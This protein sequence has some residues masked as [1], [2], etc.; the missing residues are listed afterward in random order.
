M[1]LVA[2]QFESRRLRETRRG[3]LTILAA[4]MCIVL[5]GMVAFA[6]DIG[7][8]LSSK[9]EIQRTADAWALAAAWEF[10]DCINEGYSPEDAMSIAR[11]VDNS[12][13][14]SNHVGN[15][16]PSVRLECVK[17]SWRRHGV[18]LHR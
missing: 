1:N 5:L 12:Y 9:E 13:S 3:A 6:V 8:I 7:Y 16:G 11:T 15:L 2:I 18:W 10:A 4:V 17:R 14:E